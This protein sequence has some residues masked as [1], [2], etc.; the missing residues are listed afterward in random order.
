[1]IILYWICKI[2]KKYP[3]PVFGSTIHKLSIFNEQMYCK[4]NS[5]FYVIFELFE[6]FSQFI[7]YSYH[8]LKP[9]TAIMTRWRHNDCVLTAQNPIEANHFVV[10]I[11]SEEIW[12]CEKKQ[13]YTSMVNGCYD[14]KMYWRQKKMPIVAIL[15]SSDV[16]WC[17]PL[18]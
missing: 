7:Q 2:A 13:R 15:D 14:V 8:P 16:K 1:M 3:F 4:S 10:K 18:K 11:P 9:T 17:N 12:I 5:G 6:L